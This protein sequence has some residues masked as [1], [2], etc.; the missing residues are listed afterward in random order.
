MRL[1][2]ILTLILG[3]C[4]S[5]RNNSLKTSNDYFD[6]ISKNDKE[7]KEPLPGEWR[8]R[9]NEDKQTFNDYKELNPKKAQVGETK[10]YLL[11]IGKFSTMQMK[12]LELTKEYLQIFFQLPTKILEPI[13]DALIPDTAKRTRTG[14]NVQLFTPYILNNL[15]KGKIP[16]NGYALMAISEKDLYPSS[17][18]NFVFGIA[19]Y[20]DRVG[21]SSI[22]RLQSGKLDSSNYLI[23][24]RRLLNTASH[25]IGHMF[26]I[27]HCTF[28]QCVMNGSNSLNESDKQPIRLCSECQKKLHWNTQYDNKDRLNALLQYLKVNNLRQDMSTTEDDYNTIK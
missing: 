13:S 5:Q 25:E 1:L 14:N 16:D 19:S 26:S 2:L 4:N 17:D 8:T 3:A 24:L 15:L 12:V 22:F 18:W 21:V 20:K 6:A 10:I 28:S 23:C 9:Y 7:L 11:P 27:H